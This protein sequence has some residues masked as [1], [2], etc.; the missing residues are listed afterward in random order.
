MG[1]LV[2][3]GYTARPPPPVILPAA[4]FASLCLGG[5]SRR[6]SPFGLAL[7]PAV[8]GGCCSCLRALSYDMSSATG[9]GP[10]S[11]GRH[12]DDLA[13]RGTPQRRIEALRDSRDPGRFVVAIAASA[14]KV[15]VRRGAGNAT[16]VVRATSARRAL[17]AARPPSSSVARRRLAVPFVRR[18][19]RPCCSRRS[20]GAGRD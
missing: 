15:S 20:A 9:G 18:A 13:S 12:L 19:S 16:R 7:P 14:T 4:A 3:F 10:C 17:L 2:R 5:A 11:I 1:C 6:A 8:R